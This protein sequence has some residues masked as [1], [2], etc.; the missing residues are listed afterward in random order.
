MRPIGGKNWPDRAEP[1]ISS[2]R[3]CE[4]R[5]Y[6]GRLLFLQE[7]LSLQKQRQSNRV[8]KRWSSGGQSLPAAE[9]C[10]G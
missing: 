7:L 2:F 8:P 4:F 1:I 5:I 6:N 10:E 9:G 3:E